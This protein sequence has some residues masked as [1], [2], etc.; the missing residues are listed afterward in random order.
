MQN[1]NPP[2]ASGEPQKVALITGAARRIG[3][4]IAEHL[5]QRGLKVVIH[6][7][8][9]REQADKLAEKLNAARAD[10]AAVVAA[11]LSQDQNIADLC[12]RLREQYGRLDV[13]VHNAS[14]F[15][16]TPLEQATQQQW[17][18]LMNSNVR[19]AYFLTRQ[20]ASLL[21]DSAGSIVNI[22]DVHVERPLKNH[23][24][25]CMAKSAL[26][27][28]TRSLAKDLAPDIRVNG[29]APGAILWPEGELS[30]AARQSILER[31]ALQ[32]VGDPQDIAGAVA[33]LAL[34]AP[35]VTG[36]ILAVDGGR[37]LFM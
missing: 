29:I 12:Q 1:D 8:Q 22:I 24:I 30:E 11:D 27:T 13:L 6:R 34:D 26:Q 10:S 35:Y 7:H 9:S 33:F 5:H 4:C 21:R 36:Q 20:L 19:G 18:D 32:R 23:S 15:Y 14:R 2:A 16:P 25:Y 28:M 37:S 17:D 3:A 31:I